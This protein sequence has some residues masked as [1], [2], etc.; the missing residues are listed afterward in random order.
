MRTPWKPPRLRRRAYRIHKFSGLATGIIVACSGTRDPVPRAAGSDGGA[1]G[2]ESN[3]HEPA[4]QGILRRRERGNEQRTYSIR[5]P[6]PVRGVRG[7]PWSP[8][9][10]NTQTDT[11]RVAP[12]SLQSRLNIDCW[13]RDCNQV[14]PH[15]SLGRVPPAVFAT[16]AEGPRSATPPYDA[17]LAGVGERSSVS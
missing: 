12:G 11:C 1:G 7:V 9:S 6:F 13:R 16:R 10:T 15:G 3:P 8:R 17:Q 5:C 2:W 14:Q 4:A